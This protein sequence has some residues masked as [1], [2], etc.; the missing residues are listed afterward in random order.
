MQM[1]EKADKNARVAPLFSHAGRRPPSPSPHG[2][3]TLP[4]PDRAARVDD[5]FIPQFVPS[6]WEQLFHSNG[7]DEGALRGRRITPIKETGHILT[8]TPCQLTK[9][10]IT[11]FVPI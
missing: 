2:S 6:P 1:K 4:S 7:T 5:G 11:I 3:G 8:D 10:R 9:N